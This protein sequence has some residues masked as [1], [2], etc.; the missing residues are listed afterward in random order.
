MKFD[1]K[2]AEPYIDAFFG[3]L[4]CIK[5]LGVL[6]GQK[7]VIIPTDKKE[8]K[9]ECTIYCGNSFLSLQRKCIPSA[10]ENAAAG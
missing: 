4:A 1:L 6:Q 2:F 9:C 10:L 8:D 7:G 5:W 3:W